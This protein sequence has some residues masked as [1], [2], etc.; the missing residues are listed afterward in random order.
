M[1]AIG[2]AVLGAATLTL[3]ACGGGMKVNTAKMNATKSVAIV[4]YCQTTD[5]AAFDGMNALGRIDEAAWC[6][7][8]T[9]VRL[10]PTPA[11]V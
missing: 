3:V 4:G 8:A 7:G 11:H 2:R 5:V 6:R 1:R 9:P 10:T